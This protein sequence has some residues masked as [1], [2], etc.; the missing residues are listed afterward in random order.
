MCSIAHPL[1][2]PSMVSRRAEVELEPTREATASTA[3]TSEE[4]ERAAARESALEGVPAL[5]SRRVVRVVAIVEALAELGV[6]E[7]LVGLVDGCH[8]SLGAALVG[9]RLHRGLAERL[10]DRL[11]VSVARHVEDLV[12]VLLA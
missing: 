9:V 5:A 11:R 7:D 2:T 3:S 12:V 1:M 4:L 6:C 8:L 10:P